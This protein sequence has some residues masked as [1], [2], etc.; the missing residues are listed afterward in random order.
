MVHVLGGYGVDVM[1]VY[2]LH[3]DSSIS[4]WKI[5]GTHIF[6]RPNRKITGINGLLEKVVLFDRLERFKRFISFHLH[7]FWTV[8]LVPNKFIIC[9]YSFR[10][11]RSYG[12][13]KAHT[14]KEIFQLTFLRSICTISNQMVFACK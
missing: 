3:K 14:P 4:E 10:R 9:F 12:K 1:V 5:N 7:F 8:V 13:W 2:H 6:G 11:F